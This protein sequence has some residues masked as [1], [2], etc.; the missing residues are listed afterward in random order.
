M[1]DKLDDKERAKRV[2]GVEDRVL[3]CRDLRHAWSKPVYFQVKSTNTRNGQVMRRMTCL[4]G[5]GTT[6]EEALNPRATEK[7]VQYSYA[8]GYLMPGLGRSRRGE[9]WKESL[10]RAEVQVVEE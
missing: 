3:D 8:E 2:R 7:V 1:A 4:R 5:C 10:R 6:K 9:W